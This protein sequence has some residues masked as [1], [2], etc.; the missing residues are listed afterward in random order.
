M[1]PFEMVVLDKLV[2]RST[3]MALPQRDD[4]VEAFFFD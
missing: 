2:H 4:P 3:K 1:I